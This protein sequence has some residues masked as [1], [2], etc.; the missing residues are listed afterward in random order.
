M[1]NL[2]PIPCTITERDLLRKVL[3]EFY[4]DK[5]LLLNIESSPTMYSG[6]GNLELAELTLLDLNIFAEIYKKRS[7]IEFSLN[8]EEYYENSDKYFLN[9]K[10]NRSNSWLV[11]TS[12]AKHYCYLD[13][14]QLIEV[15]VFYNQLSNSTIVSITSEALKQDF[16]KEQNFNLSGTLFFED[17]AFPNFNLVVTQFEKD[18]FPHNTS[19]NKE[20]H[21]KVSKLKEELTQPLKGLKYSD[22]YHNEREIQFI[23]YSNEIYE[24]LKLEGLNLGNNIIDIQANITRFDDNSIIIDK[25]IS[26][27]IVNQ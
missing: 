18:D 3:F 2:P 14:Y 13:D 26:A 16:K 10:F 25:L 21:K 19:G 7:S 23:Y 22:F 15:M 5:A 24:A 1:E 20:L 27:N 12:R 6:I 4:V 9:K 11:N 8:S 17:N